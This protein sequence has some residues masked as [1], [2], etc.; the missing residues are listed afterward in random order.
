MRSCSCKNSRETTLAELTN[1]EGRLPAGDKGDRGLRAAQLS[2]AGPGTHDSP[3]TGSRRR[4]SSKLNTPPGEEQPASPEV[5][6]PSDSPALMAAQ[7]PPS[8]GQRGFQEAHPTCSKA[9]SLHHISPSHSWGL[10]VT[11]LTHGALRLRTLQLQPAETKSRFL[12]VFCESTQ[13]LGQDN[14]DASAQ[15]CCHFG[16]SG[17]GPRV[18]GRGGVGGGARVGEGPE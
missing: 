10:A 13:D 4:T 5:P 6:A 11:P 8:Q 9:E 7:L 18:R 16:T 15:A 14:R 3:R 17:R 2:E 1:G 12:R